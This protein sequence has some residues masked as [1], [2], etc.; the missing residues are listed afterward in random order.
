MAS[1]QRSASGRPAWANRHYRVVA[2]DLWSY[3]SRCLYIPVIRIQID[4]DRHL[5]EAVLAEAFEQSCVTFPLIACV[6]DTTPPIRP[7]WTPRREAAREILQ[8]VETRAD[9]LREDEIQRVF[10]GSPD[11]SKG[12]QLCAFLVRDSM[13]DSL[14][15][16][17][18]HMLCD[19]AGFKQYLRE[20]A[21]LYSRIVAGL[22]P[23]P[24]PFDSQRSILP[25]LKRFTPLDWLL[26]PPSALGP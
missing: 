24:A 20:V 16:T 9:T 22:D 25:V 17:I 21:R 12:P 18:N 7:R 10:A 15:L 2:F 19:A 8:V 26:P 4:F 11:I 5:D 23:S 13:R 3:Y 14:C 1:D 6:F